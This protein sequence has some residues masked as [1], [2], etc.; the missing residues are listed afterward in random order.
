MANVLEA[1]LAQ[2]EAA[3]HAH[4][5]NEVNDRKSPVET[6]PGFAVERTRRRVQKRPASL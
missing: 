6:K 3:G 4:A 2:D 1:N 5:H